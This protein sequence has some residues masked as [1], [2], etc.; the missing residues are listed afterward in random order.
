MWVCD[1]GALRNT[2]GQYLE[3]ES[4]LNFCPRSHP[5][6]IFHGETC[7]A[8][9]FQ[10]NDTVVQKEKCEPEQNITCPNIPCANYGGKNFAKIQ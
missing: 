6:S 2:M 4:N 5:H 10:Y 1:N 9:H 8:K 7:C 3:F